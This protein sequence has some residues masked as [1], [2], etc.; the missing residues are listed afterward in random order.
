MNTVNTKSI[1]SIQFCSHTISHSTVSKLSARHSTKLQQMYQ[2]KSHINS[3]YEV[4]GGCSSSVWVT[5]N[6]LAVCFLKMKEQFNHYDTIYSSPWQARNKLPHLSAL[7]CK[8][9]PDSSMRPCPTKQDI[10]FLV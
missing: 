9:Q 10:F 4:E 7:F 3:E 1:G 2:G 5:F 8:P 6:M